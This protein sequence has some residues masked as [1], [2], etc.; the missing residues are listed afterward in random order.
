VVYFVKLIILIL[1]NTLNAKV[2][3]RQELIDV[4]N[5]LWKKYDKEAKG[6]I[7][8]QQFPIMLRLLD[9]NPTNKEVQ[10]MLSLLEEDPNNPQGMISKEGFLYCVA[11]KERDTNT[12]D[13]LLASIKVFDKE[14]KGVLEEKVLRYI[15]CKTGDCLSTEEMDAL[16]KEAI[17]F[18]KIDNDIKYI[19]IND[20]ALFLKDRYKPPEPEDKKK[21]K[22]KGRK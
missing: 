6:F 20:L 11:R 21:G 16:M 5:Q 13:E 15:L 2:Y 18:T 8:P 12:Y 10:E 1:M 22:N 17:P 14:N 7:T 19:N 3:V 9:Y 4:I